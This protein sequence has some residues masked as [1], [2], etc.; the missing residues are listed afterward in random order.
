MRLLVTLPNNTIRN[1]T[2]VS[3]PNHFTLY[4]V[5]PYIICAVNCLAKEVHHKLS[6]AKL[7]H[8][9]F[10]KYT[11]AATTRLFLLTIIEWWVIVR[12]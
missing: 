9:N 3:C 1:D 11:F 10:V 8:H 12:E 5:I 7:R 4:H 6:L 2:H